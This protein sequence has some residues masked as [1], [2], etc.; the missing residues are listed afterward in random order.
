MSTT[1][2]QTHT[3]TPPRQASN[4]EVMKL[5]AGFSGDLATLRGDTLLAG[6][7]TGHEIARLQERAA[8]VETANELA[9]KRM[10]R[11]QEHLRAQ[12]QEH[13]VTGAKLFAAVACIGVLLLAA[14]QVPAV[15]A[16]FGL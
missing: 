16:W 7:A 8:L 12:L 11:D 4:I 6:Q 5:I 1:T 13:D 3:G 15:R 10:V 2:E 14:W 9:M